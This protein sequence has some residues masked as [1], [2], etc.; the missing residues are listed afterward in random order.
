MIVIKTATMIAQRR[1]A[2]RK[3]GDVGQP[4]VCIRRYIDGDTDLQRKLVAMI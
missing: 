3:L 2:L 1:Q 4:D